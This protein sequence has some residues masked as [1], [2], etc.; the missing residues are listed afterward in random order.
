[1]GYKSIIERTI[2]I[3]IGNSTETLKNKCDVYIEPP[4][5]GDYGT[6]DFKKIDEIYKIGYNHAQSYKEELLKL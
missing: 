1:M 5:M 6:F 3:A 2:H 4:N